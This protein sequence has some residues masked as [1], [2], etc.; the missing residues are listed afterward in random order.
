MMT[1]LYSFIFKY[2]IKLY[3]HIITSKVLHLDPV[4]KFIFSAELCIR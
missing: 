3:M 4:F 1:Y 2:G